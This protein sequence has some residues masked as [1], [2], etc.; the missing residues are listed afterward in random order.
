MSWTSQDTIT[1]RMARLVSDLD[2]QRREEAR[3]RAIQT[4]R[5]VAATVCEPGCS[6]RG[7]GGGA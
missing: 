4:A 5:L 2:A 1:L 6:C 7:K 3:E